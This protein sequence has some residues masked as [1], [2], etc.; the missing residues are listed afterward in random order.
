MADLNI[1]LEDARALQSGEIEALRHLISEQATQISDL[2][3]RNSNLDCA[4]TRKF[5]RSREN[6]VAF[7]G[8]ATTNQRLS[9][10]EA[11]MDTLN[12]VVPRTSARISELQTAE[13]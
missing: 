5:Q 4:V 7:G 10:L 12:A 2:Q 3:N 1:A 6:T 13:N 9:N 8:L 11:Q